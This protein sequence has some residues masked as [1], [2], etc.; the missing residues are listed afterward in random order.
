M[1]FT[2]A[3]ILKKRMEQRHTDDPV[4]ALV[5]E[6][7]QLERRDEAREPSS[8]ARTGA[9]HELARVPVPVEHDPP[10][11]KPEPRGAIATSQI[12]EVPYPSDE[13]VSTLL[14][15]VKDVT[16]AQVPVTSKTASNCLR[17]ARRYSPEA[18][19][20][21][22]AGFIRW[23]L[24]TGG[25]R[26]R[27]WGGIC[28]A[29]LGDFA[30]WKGGQDSDAGQSS[31]L[32]AVREELTRLQRALPAETS[33]WSS[34]TDSTASNILIEVRKKAPAATSVEIAFRVREI[35]I[36]NRFKGWGGVVT[37]LRRAW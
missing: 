20:A 30:A 21:D 36:A 34:V 2:L 4:D 7:L 12:A 23:K 6:G 18:T 33:G 16:L 25:T 37:A 24:R 15:Q 28:S 17:A 29:L 32:A 31:I 27:G 1:S 13:D 10:P 9:E 8:V 11:Q 35:I 22:V 19:P 5:D 3:E 26:F 14:A